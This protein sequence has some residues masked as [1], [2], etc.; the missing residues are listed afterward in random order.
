MANL[1][2]QLVQLESEQLVRRLPD[3]ELVYLFKHTL[4]QETAYESLLLKRRREIHR[5]VAEAYEEIEAGRLDEVAALL[6]Q[7]YMLAGDDAKTLE[8][9]VRAGDSAARMYANAEAISHYT[10][11]L[12]LAKRLQGNSG[13]LLRMYSAR[14]RAFELRGDYDRALANYD[15][16]AAEAIARGDRRLEL[17]ALMALATVHATPTAKFDPVRAQELSE[18]TLVLARELQDRQA[19]AKVLWNRM[20]LFRWTGRAAEAIQTGE[21][22]IEIA[23][24]F[25]L[26]EQLAYTLNDIRELYLQTRQVDRARAAGAEALKL[27]RELDNK[28]MMIDNLIGSSGDAYFAGRYDEALAVSANAFQLSQ[29]IGNLWGQSYSLMNDGPIHL[30]RGQIQEA[31]AA[32]QECARLGEEAGFLIA[33]LSSQ[34][35]IAITWAVM[36]NPARGLELLSPPLE[37]SKSLNL[38]VATGQAA[39]TLI[40][41]LNGQT[42]R[43]DAAL[44]ECYKSMGEATD[45]TTAV[46]SGVAAGQLALTRQDHNRALKVV[47]EVLGALQELGAK[48]FLTDAL[49]LKCRAETNLGQADAAYATLTRARAEA[50]AIGTRRTLWE[51][52]ALL[53]D[54]EEQR[55]NDAAAGAM[56][57]QAAQIVHYIAAHTP[58][59]LRTSFLN[60]PP[61]RRLLDMRG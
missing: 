20:L 46:L 2:A 28:P 51:I 29:S 25:D 18:R 48:F 26:R 10:Q 33:V 37:R 1:P 8:Y 31:L 30:E 61:I 3:E 47:D 60:L 9:S 7:H 55:G 19:E 5:R 38:M 35:L 11:A 53:A 14:G 42:D 52:L 24:E 6:A 43:A 41:L 22:A 50:E 54:M 44:Q 58:D 45:P 16:M 23:R 40:L 39:L 21:S 34:S 49:L 13:G 59:E 12:D 27:F 4:T 17:A 32:M 36:G 57:E 56:R 15:D